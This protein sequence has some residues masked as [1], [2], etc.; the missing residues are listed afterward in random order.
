MVQEARARLGVGTIAMRKAPRR[1]PRLLAAGEVVAIV[2]DQDARWKG[3]WVPFF[4]TP[5][6]TF[7]GPA[8]FALRTGAPVLASISRRLPD[9]RY[10]VEGVRVPVVHTGDR[11]ADELRLTADLAAL[12]ESEIRKDPG[13][14]FWFHKRWKTSPPEEL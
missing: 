2:G 12:L 7:R 1:V 13:Q 4:G 8:Q 9:G 11:E 3:V 5:A 14:Y 10:R 6:S